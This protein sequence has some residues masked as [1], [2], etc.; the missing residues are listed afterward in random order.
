ML[1]CQGV[2][3]GEGRGKKPLKASFSSVKN[4]LKKIKKSLKNVEKMLDNIKGDV[5]LYTSCRRESG[6]TEL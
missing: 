3:T 6:Q 5:V 2:C 1:Y 4:F